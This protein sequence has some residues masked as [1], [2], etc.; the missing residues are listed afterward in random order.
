M[1]TYT[2]TPQNYVNGVS[3]VVEVK[4]TQPFT[5]SKEIH[6][7]VT[8]DRIDKIPMKYWRRVEKGTI[9]GMVEMA[10]WFLADSRGVFYTHDEAMNIVDEMPRKQAM[11]MVTTISAQIQEVSAGKK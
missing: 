1:S 9:E 3:E 6:V 11:D 5:K 4:Q 8:P 10:A 2:V 7:L